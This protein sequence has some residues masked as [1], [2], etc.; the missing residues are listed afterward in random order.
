MI[1]EISKKTFVLSIIKLA[2]TVVA[3]V[4]MMFIPWN[5]A[6]LIVGSYADLTHGIRNIEG[7]MSLFGAILGTPFLIL[8]IVIF[9]K[10]ILLFVAVMQQK[11]GQKGYGLTQWK[12]KFKV[13]SIIPLSVLYFIT[14]A[15]LSEG[16]YLAKFALYLVIL[17]AIADG[18]ICGMFKKSL[19]ITKKKTADK[20]TLTDSA[21]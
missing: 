2:W 17:Y 4:L 7:V 6:G 12:K 10:N 16:S 18:V 14:Y 20:Q 15:F 21:Q 11:S 9:I 1:N 8:S 13:I 5:T 3:L 19:G